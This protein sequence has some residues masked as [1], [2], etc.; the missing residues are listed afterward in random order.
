MPEAGYRMLALLCSVVGAVP[1]GTNL[2]LLHLVWMLASGRRL[3]SRG[4]VIPGLAECGLSDRAV[5]RA[6]AALGQGGWTSAGLRGDWAAVVA[7][8]GRWQAQDHGGD[9]PVAVAVTA[10]GRP[11]LRGGPTTHDHGAAGR[12][13]PASPLG[14]IARVGRV[15]AQR[16]ALPLACVRA[17]AADPR[18][19]THERLLVRAAVRLCAGDAVLVLDRGFGVALLQG[20][21]ATRFVVRAAKHATFR[22]ATPPAYGGRGRP[23]TCG[24]TVRPLPRT[25]RGRALPATPPARTATWREGDA[26]LRAAVW[27]ALVRADA[28]VGAATFSVLAI[29][30]PRHREPL[31]LV[32]PLALTPPQA[33]E[34]YRD[35]WPVE[36]L[37]LAAKPLLGAARQFVHAPE[38]CPRLPELALLAGAVRSYAA[39]TTPAIPTGCWDRRPQPTPG[40][41]RRCLARTTFPHDYPLPGRIREKAARTDHLRTGCW[42]Q[43]RRAV[44]TMLPTAADTPVQH[45]AAVA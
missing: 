10:F 21:G 38:T 31:L 5:R 36:Q 11:R 14:L 9:R 27:D 4:A 8:E 43:R 12:A 33:R 17:D 34:C 35:R 24:E 37:P 3:G 42:G 40:R 26:V 16:L 13:L 23:P 45:L 20:E 2:G 28:Q 15:G 7:G 25:Y 39:A 22:R 44:P 32:T 6:W 1:S 41:L 30:D 19:S 18:T 29:H